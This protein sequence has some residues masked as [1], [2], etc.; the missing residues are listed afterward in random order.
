VKDF[1]DTDM[2][3]QNNRANEQHQRLMEQLRLYD[4]AAEVNVHVMLLGVSG[5]I[6]N[7]CIAKLRHL[8]VEGELLETLLAELHF[9]AIESLVQIWRYRQHKIKSRYPEAAAH[10]LKPFARSKNHSGRQ[11][12][13]RKHNKRK[14]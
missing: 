3:T 7:S 12:L 2:V 4:P 9:S 13:H 8:G 5:C 10:R 6:Y 14:K 1:R 11:V